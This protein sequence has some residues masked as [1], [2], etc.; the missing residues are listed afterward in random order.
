MNADPASFGRV[1]ALSMRAMKTRNS[2]YIADV[3]EQVANKLAPAPT[4]DPRS[5]ANG[6]AAEAVGP[7]AIMSALGMTND[8]AQEGYNR[9]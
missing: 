2:E 4:M 8:G 5:V 7:S 9:P 6:E 3:F 1:V